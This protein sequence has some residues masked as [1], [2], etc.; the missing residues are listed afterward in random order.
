MAEQ[1]GSQQDLNR[2]RFLSL[3][4]LGAG[5]LTLAAC[6]AQAPAAAPAAPA[7]TSAPAAA[8][9]AAAFDAAKCYVP[10]PGTSGTIKFDAKPGPYKIALSNSYI[11]NVWRTQM[12]KMAKAYVELPEIK[13]DI[14]E[15]IYQSS[16]ESADT[17]I[18][19]MENMIA[20][21][22]NAIIINAIS[23]TALNPTVKKAQD[24]GIAIVAFD[25]VVTQ[26]KV[27][28]INEDQVEFGRRMAQWLAD[29]IGGKGNII[30][31]TGVEGTTVNAERNQGAKEVFANYP[32]IKIVA[33]VNG[34]WDPGTAQQ[35]VAAAL[36]SAPDLAG[37]WCQGGTDGVVR[38]LQQA[39]RPLIPIA[40][41]AENGFRKQLLQFKDQGLTGISIGQTPGMVCVSIRAAIDLLKGQELPTYISVPLPIATSDELQDGV[42]VFLN[43]PDNFFTPIQIPDCG[44]N[45]TYEQIE[46]QQV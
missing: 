7:A 30:M 23:P 5:G 36:S 24:A 12:I 9:V 11:G 42:N 40:G 26:E 46:S 8:P 18:S 10:T 3:V 43:G 16:G 41:E 35:V 27:V 6:G 37:I 21:G 17:Q 44:V 33:E 14:A 34:K 31:V 13:P 22:V 28:I 38:A 39:G 20:S 32:D 29:A 2:R 19:Q 25:N 45:L 15:F 4:T 1:N